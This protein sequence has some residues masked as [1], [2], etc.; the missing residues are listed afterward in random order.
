MSLEVSSLRATAHPVRLRIL[1]LLTGAAMSAA[2]LAREI[3]TTQAN[4]S[5]HLRIL[6]SAGLVEIAGE[7]KIRG[8]VAK[9]YRHPWQHPRSE[10]AERAPADAGDLSM[11]WQAMAHELIRRAQEQDPDP[12]QATPSLLTD[13]E[14][15]VEPELWRRACDL[16]KEASGLLHGEAKPP[17]SPGTV[18]VNAQAALFPMLDRGPAAPAAHQGVR[19]QH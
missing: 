5:Y 16:V 13:A 14:L 19:E 2:E 18:H 9:R 4:A 8:G 11:A 6:A 12:G 10:A 17:R 3:G 7:E 15:W 1:S